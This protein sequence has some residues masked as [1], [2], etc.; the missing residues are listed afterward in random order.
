MGIDDGDDDACGYQACNISDFF[1]SDTLI[2][3]L[4]FD[5]GV[6]YDDVDE[7]NA[8]PDYKCAEP[9]RLFDMAEECLALPLLKETTKDNK[10]I[11]I[12]PCQESLNDG[13]NDNLHLAINQ[14]RSS[15]Q[16]FD[17][18]TDL[19]HAED[20]DPQLFIEKF[21]ELSEVVLNFH[22]VA[23]QK[24]PQR[25]KSVTLVLDLDGKYQLKTQVST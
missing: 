8:L 19:D 22:P 18:K 23:H 10:S 20:V 17:L 24:E 21:P 7:M 6:V 15:K 3:S 5:G 9:G 11:D 13:N 25:R 4:P 2:A 14:I 1:I 12:E 16:V